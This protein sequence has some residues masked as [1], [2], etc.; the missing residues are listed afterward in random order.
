MSDIHGVESSNT[1]HNDIEEL[2]QRVQMVIDQMEEPGSQSYSS[3]HPDQ[4]EQ[5]RQVPEKILDN[6]Y[7]F[8]AK[9][10]LPSLQKLV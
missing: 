2:K 5:P 1:I 7:F 4:D 3:K 8:C 6:F 10:L 9:T